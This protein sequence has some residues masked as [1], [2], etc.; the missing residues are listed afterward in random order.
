MK[1]EWI[2][3]FQSPRQARKFYF[4][5]SDTVDSKARLAADGLSVTLKVAAWRPV[6]LTESGFVKLLVE[7]LAGEKQHV[8]D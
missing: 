8:P 6:N 1:Q 3:N 4:A 5:V 7:L 2:V